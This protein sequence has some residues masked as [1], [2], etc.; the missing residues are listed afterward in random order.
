MKTELLIV[1]GRIRTVATSDWGTDDQPTD[2]TFETTAD[3]GNTISEKMRIT[4][5]GYLGI[6]TTTPGYNLER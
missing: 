3:G 1:V 2:M 6:G 4:Q 5:A